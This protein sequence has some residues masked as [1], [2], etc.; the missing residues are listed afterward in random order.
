MFK[1]GEII[2]FDGTRRRLSVQ[3]SAAQ[4]RGYKDDPRGFNR[5]SLLRRF[6][7]GMGIRAVGR[8]HPEGEAGMESEIRA[9]LAGVKPWEAKKAA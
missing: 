6:M 9:A 4:G 5:R 8:R 2:Q 1:V 3:D 7:M